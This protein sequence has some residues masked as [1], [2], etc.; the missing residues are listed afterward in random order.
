MGSQPDHHEVFTALHMLC[1]NAIAECEAELENQK[2]SDR[3]E[4]QLLEEEKKR[5]EDAAKFVAEQENKN[6]LESLRK[7]EK[8]RQEIDAAE[9]ELE[10]KKA[11]LRN[12]EKGADGGEDDNEEEDEEEEGSK[13]AP[14]DAV[15]RPFFD[16]FTPLYIEV[17]QQLYQGTS[18]KKTKSDLEDA[19]KKA[20][21][22]AHSVVSIYSLAIK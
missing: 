10:A 21:Q 5:R 14:E 1:A 13:S 6:R 7:M 11:A 20:P 2:A 16:I 19:R 8:G 15:V 3:A 12:A 22:T 17:N 4:A 18:K 9:R